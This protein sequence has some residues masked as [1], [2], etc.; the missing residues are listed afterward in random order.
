MSKH[1]SK[2]LVTLPIIG[3]F[4]MIGIEYLFD[5]TVNEAHIQ[6]IEFMI[7]STIVGGV[8][9]ASFKRFTDYKAKQISG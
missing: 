2:I 5:F 6:L 3:G 9:N 4:I 7:G 1:F 8:G